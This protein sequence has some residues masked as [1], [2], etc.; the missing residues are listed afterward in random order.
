MTVGL[1][2]K[3]C[4][5]KSQSLINSKAEMTFSN[6][7]S[8]IVY[9]GKP[10]RIREE[11][12]S[13]KSEITSAEGYW[14]KNLEEE[15]YEL[16]AVVLFKEKVCGMQIHHNPDPEGV[17]SF[18]SKIRTR[19]DFEKKLAEIRKLLLTEPNAPPPI[20]INK[21]FKSNRQKTAQE[22]EP[23]TFFIRDSCAQQ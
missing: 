18:S 15:R 11:I 16:H 3:N 21:K 20:K 4:F 19:N 6:K 12:E 8:F 2:K 17:R 1:R 10:E 13:K 7:V 14:K 9:F 5:K 23:E 22:K